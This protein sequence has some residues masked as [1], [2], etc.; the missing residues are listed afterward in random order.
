MAFKCIIC[1]L[2]LCNCYCLLE[3]ILLCDLNCEV[4]RSYINY[5][6]QSLSTFF[7]KCIFG[8]VLSD[9]NYEYL[10]ILLCE[11]IA[12][13]GFEV[14]WYFWNFKNFFKNIF[15]KKVHYFWVLTLFFGVYCGFDLFLGFKG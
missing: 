2:T 5:T 6:E 9:V 1:V 3:H 12:R 13:N 7:K 8:S 4:L 15:F 10:L 11:I 14:E